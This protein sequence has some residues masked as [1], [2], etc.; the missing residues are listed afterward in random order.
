[1]GIYSLR[2]RTTEVHATKFTLF[3]LVS[4]RYL[5]LRVLGKK[6][7]ASLSA[8]QSQLAGPR[9]QRQH[10]VRSLMSSSLANRLAT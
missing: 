8:A 7:H 3:C 4:A 6:E 9:Y 5:S 1:M 10:Q 2:R